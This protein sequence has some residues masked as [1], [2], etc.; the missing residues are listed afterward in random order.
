M[1]WDD[2]TRKSVYSANKNTGKQGYILYLCF[3]FSLARSFSLPPILLPI[4]SSCSHFKKLLKNCHIK[5]ALGKSWKIVFFIYVYVYAKMI[6]Y[7]NTTRARV[8]EKFFFRM[9]LCRLIEL[10]YLGKDLTILKSDFPG[11]MD[12]KM[13]SPHILTEHTPC[14]QHTCDHICIAL[15]PG[16]QTK[17]R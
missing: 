3:L 5:N 9:F 13:Y 4:Y 15:P 6:F 14:S 12:L 1:Y 17:Y 10:I 11:A 7:D 16:S 2:W 8:N